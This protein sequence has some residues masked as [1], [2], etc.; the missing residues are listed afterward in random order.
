MR[1]LLVNPNTSASVTALLTAE[2]RRA[3]RPDTTVVPLTAPVGVPYIETD[4]EALVGGMAALEL[5]A[6]HETEADVAIIAAFGDPGLAAAKAAVSIPV[7]GLSEA[8]FL[9]AAAAAES[10]GIVAI[11]PRMQT[12]YRRAVD[13]QHMGPRFRGFRILRPPLQDVARIQTDRAD[14]LI[15]LAAGLVAEEGAGTV[16][17]AGAPLAGFVR[18]QAPRL[19]HPAI[20]GTAAAVHLA[21]ALAGMAQRG[22]SVR[23][24]PPRGIKPVTGLGPDLARL[25]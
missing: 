5:I 19:T 20:D 24:A 15:D 4:A 1:I 10:F 22:G 2:A 12:W 13:Q 18:A 7:L 9:M 16:I 3:A 11:S 14:E 21:E 17:F 23:P 6:R 25:F 8:A